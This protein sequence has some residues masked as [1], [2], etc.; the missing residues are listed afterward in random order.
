MENMLLGINPNFFEAQFN[1]NS[2]TKNIKK[3]CPQTK[4]YKYRAFNCGDEEV[5]CG[6][7]SWVAPAQPRRLTNTARDI[8]GQ[9]QAATTQ[10]KGLAKAYLAALS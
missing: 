2:M 4:P 6:W 9:S 10:P 5:R 7:Q 8:G 3:K 1:R